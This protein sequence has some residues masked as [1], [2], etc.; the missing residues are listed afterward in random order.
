MALVSPLPKMTYEAMVLKLGELEDLPTLPTVVQRILRATADER[1]GAQ[2]LTTLIVNDQS[3]AARILKVSNSAFYGL[4]SKVASVD[5]AVSVIGFDEVRR[6][7]LAALVAKS[8]PDRAGIASFPLGHFWVHSAAVAYA[9]REIAEGAGS[10]ADEAFTAGLL[11]DIGKLVA[12]QFF[13]KHFF[14]VAHY[15]QSLRLEMHDVELEI[16]GVHHGAV[17]AILAGVWDLP[18]FYAKAMSHHHLPPVRGADDP[19][20]ERLVDVVKLADALARRAK[21]GF[22]GSHNLPGWPDGAAQRLNLS[23]DDLGRLERGCAGRRG[24]LDQFFD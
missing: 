23:G 5:R 24:M 11:H 19:E 18:P 15:A 10:G 6:I 9:A 17:G 4:R 3:L 2:D 14:L 13:P 16:L 22:S 7:A 20:G 8:F 21:I 12:C 1:T